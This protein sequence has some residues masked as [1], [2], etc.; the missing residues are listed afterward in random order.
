METK[1][2]SCPFQTITIEIQNKSLF[3][4]PIP[5]VIE[6]RSTQADQ[7]TIFWASGSNAFAENRSILAERSIEPKSDVRSFYTFLSP[8]LPINQLKI[9]PTYTGVCRPDT[10][11][12]VVYRFKN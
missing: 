1:E 7:I 6:T 12:I 8:V 3:Q 4:L 10:L 11:N 5:I 2:I 9:K